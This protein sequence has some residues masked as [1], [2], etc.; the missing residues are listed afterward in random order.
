MKKI[1][2]GSAAALVASAGIAAADIELKGDGRMGVV[3]DTAND[4]TFRSRA[5]V[6]FVL[7][8][9]TDTGLT[10]GGDFRAHEAVNANNGT[11]G[12]VFVGGD[13]G[14]LRMGAV[15][16]ALEDTMFNTTHIGVLENNQNSRITALGAT[17]TGI[18]Y[19][20][21]LDGFN[22]ALGAGQLNTGNQELS[23]GASYSFDGFGVALGYE[24]VRG[25]DDHI[26]LSGRASFDGVTAVGFF[27]RSG[28][29][30]QFGLSVTASFDD[31]GV[32]ARG[33][34]DFAGNN[35]LGL[36]VSYDLGGGASMGASA[37]RVSGQ[38]TTAD[39]GIAFTF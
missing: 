26:L 3:R 5:R 32:Q 25:G 29:N 39:F 17:A 37:N 36:G 6:Q 21:G 18:L 10:F 28:G 7:S 30:D 13:F 9:Q 2:L 16:S 20:Y 38:G 15:D 24:N 4:Y 33:K 27:G 19:T 23:L 34:R 11:A 31:I 12:T 8:G 14:T 35:H 22:V 1:L